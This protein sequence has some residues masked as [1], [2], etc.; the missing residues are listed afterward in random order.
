M[1]TREGSG[2]QVDVTHGSTGQVAPPISIGVPVHGFAS[3]DSSFLERP[4]DAEP[5]PGQNRAP[6]FPV[7]HALA[8]VVPTSHHDIGRAFAL[9]VSG[10][11][12]RAI[13]RE[14]RCLLPGEM[15]VPAT[16]VATPAA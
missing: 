3:A 5:S 10:E 2:M 1:T 13:A 9:F 11:R 15:L 8:V 14:N 12:G 4:A 16:L 6:H 7:G